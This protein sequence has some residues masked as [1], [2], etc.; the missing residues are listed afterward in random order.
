MT[1]TGTAVITAIAATSARVRCLGILPPFLL[2][3]LSFNRPLRPE[4][5]PGDRVSLF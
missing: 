2:A 5:L 3:Y 1:D 4:L